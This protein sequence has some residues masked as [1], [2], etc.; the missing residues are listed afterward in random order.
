MTL[1]F[2]PHWRSY[3]SSSFSTVRV[4]S[5]SFL[6]LLIFLPTVLIPAYDSFNPAFC[7][8]YSAYKLNKQ[9]DNIQPCLTPFPILN[10]SVVPYKVP[11]VTPWPAYKCLRRQVKWSGIC[12]SKGFVVVNFG[13][14]LEI[15]SKLLNWWLFS[16]IFLVWQ[17][18]SHA[19][20]WKTSQNIL[21]SQHFLLKICSCFHMVFYILSFCL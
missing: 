17:C 13:V 1:L 12:T 10:Q 6:R 11:V 16:E 5:S 15:V 7:I 2:H 18:L 19:Y 14:S 9:S 3:S 20:S 8:M 4:I 21:G